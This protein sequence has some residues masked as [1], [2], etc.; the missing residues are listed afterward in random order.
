V[1]ECKPLLSG[2]GG[3]CIASWTAVFDEVFDT[4]MCEDADADGEGE[5]G[6]AVS[7]GDLVGWCIGS[8]L[9]PVLKVE[10]A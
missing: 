5:G 1:N 4:L 10:S 3:Q 2:C 6:A 9:K 7:C 8:K